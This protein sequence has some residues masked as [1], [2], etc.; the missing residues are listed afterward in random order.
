[1]IMETIKNKPRKMRTVDESTKEANI[2]EN[3]NDLFSQKTNEERTILIAKAL[4]EA[5]DK[6][7]CLEL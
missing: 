4:V 5:F 1:M 2:C 6:G 7:T 3:G